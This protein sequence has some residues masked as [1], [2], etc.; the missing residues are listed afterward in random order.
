MAA[1]YLPMNGEARM[2][3]CSNL[4]AFRAFED[5]ISLL[6]NRTS[7]NETY[8]DECKVPICGALWGYGVPDVSGIGVSSDH[9]SVLHF[10]IPWSFHCPHTYHT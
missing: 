9:S 3:D 5:Y 1:Q 10:Y 7:F 4:Y 2:V 6:R 8:L